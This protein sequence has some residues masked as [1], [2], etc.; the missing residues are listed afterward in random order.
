M[1]PLREKNMVIDQLEDMKNRMD[2]LYTQSFGGEPIREEEPRVVPEIWQPLVDIFQNEEE[3]LVI[4]D[5]PGVL[6]T[7]LKVEIV[8][9][10]L[11]IAGTR[12]GSPLAAHPHSAVMERSEGPFSRTFKLPHDVRQ[13][14]IKAELKRGVLTVTIPKTRSNQCTHRI[15]VHSK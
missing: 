3:W 7:D 5:L 2:S 9:N 4:A 1:D 14:D 6:D 11:I 13:E 15:V 12:A 8:E 10:R